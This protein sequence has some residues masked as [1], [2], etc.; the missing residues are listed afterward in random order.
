MNIEKGP[1]KTYNRLNKLPLG[2]ITPEGWL[3]EQM[4]RSAAGIGG[5]LDVMEPVGIGSP[6][7]N[8]S[9]DAGLES[10]YQVGWSTEQSGTYWLGLVQLAFTLQDPVL[11][12][13][14]TK[15]VDAVLTNA[16]ED[17][18]LGGYTPEDDRMEDYNPWG[19]N[20]GL[21]ALLCFYEATG[22]E[23]VLTAVHRCLLWFVDNWSDHHTEYAAI[24][25]ADSMAVVYSYTGDNRL[26]DWVLQYFD[27]LEEH[28]GWPNRISDFLSDELP[29]NS[30]H[31]GA[32]AEWCKNPALIYTANGDERFLRASVNTMKKTMDIAQLTGIPSSNN[33]FISPVSAVHETEYC[34]YVAFAN[35]FTWMTLITGESF[36]MDWVEKIV[37]NGAQAAR[38]K[39]ERGLAYLSAPNQIYATRYSSMFGSPDRQV[40]ASCYN[41]ACCPCNSVRIMPEY[42]RGMAMTDSVGG[43]YLTAYGPA[44]L[45]YKS[46]KL[47]MD[48]LYPFRD[49]VD[50]VVEQGEDNL[51]IYVRI[52]G[53]CK[54]PVIS[55][56][57][58]EQTVSQT[59]GY[60]KITRMWHTGDKLTLKFPMQVNVIRVNDKD[61]AGKL[62]MA[63]EYG[64][65]LF[66]YKIPEQWVVYEGNPMTKAPD[67]PWYEAWPVYPQVDK[68]AYDEGSSRYDRFT[69]NIA[70]D[71][72]LSPS[73]VKVELHELSCA[74][75]WENPP[76]NLQIPVYKAKYAYTIAS[77]RTEEVYEAPVTVKGEAYQVNLEPYGCTALRIS[78][79]PRAKLGKKY[80]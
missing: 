25:I 54:N 46:L 14:A 27:W 47:H 79:F 8:R 3:R 11:I 39:D 29:Y 68:H 72:N 77:C 36:Y 19:T 80:K 34:D 42:V 2:S 12:D 48:T 58:E 30:M 60:V 1:V 17:G 22:R 23:D 76:L 43:L 26:V 28:S 66:A 52:P 50:I 74:F 69:W 13:K 59:D 31:L 7:I 56:N 44:R 18:Y 63:I 10:Y 20:M 57:G 4:V 15:W 35:S 73:D 67:W 38:K 5:N 62:P 9:R 64:P 40:Y 21:R 49:T 71:E 24:N 6:F 37:F 45:R 33:E 41:V 55:I 78:Y 70:V 53:W 51:P 16:Y 75:P 65:L 61:A 32:L